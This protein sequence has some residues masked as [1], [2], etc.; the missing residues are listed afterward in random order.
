MIRT[1]IDGRINIYD[2]KSQTITTLNPADRTYQVLD[3]KQAVTSMPTM[4][5]KIKLEATASVEPLP[6]RTTIAGKPAKKYKG[7]ATIRMGAEGMASGAY[8]TTKIE[9][10]QWVTESVSEGTLQAT[11]AP[12]KQFTGPLEPYGGME[13]VIKEF[14]KMKG[15]PLS[16]RV[17]VTMSTSGNGRAPQGPITTTTEVQVV[18]ESPLSDSLFQIPDGYQRAAIRTPQKPNRKAP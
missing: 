2:T 1:E 5:A 18:D 16:S 9:L 12:L 15:L 8:P 7:S 3:L 6:D 14:S 13:S 17:T 4:L 10:E 11:L